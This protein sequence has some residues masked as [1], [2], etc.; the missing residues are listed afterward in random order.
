MLEYAVLSLFVVYGVSVNIQLFLL[1]RSVNRLLV[2]PPIET[3]KQKIL[4]S[5]KRVLDY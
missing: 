5:S 1:K 2:S 4:V 3:P